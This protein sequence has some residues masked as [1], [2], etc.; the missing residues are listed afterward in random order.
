M[1]SFFAVLLLSFGLTAHAFAQT[2]ICTTGLCLQQVSCPGTQT[3]T[4][5]GFIY[6]PNGTDPLPNVTV[7][8]PNAAVDPFS[9]GVTCAVAGAPP[10][11][12]PIVGT[13]TGVDGKFILTNVPVGASIPIVAVSGRWRVQAQ[14]PMTTACADTAFSMNMP[15]N[16]TQG[17]IPKIAIATGS[18]DQVECVLLKMGIAQS[19]FTNPGG[20]GR[21]NLFHGD[22]SP[23]TG[24]V[25]IDTS[26]PTESILMGTND[27]TNAVLSQYDVLMLPCEGGAS[28]RAAQELANLVAFANAGGRVYASHFSYGWMYTNPPFNKVAS[29]T[30]NSQTLSD[31]IATVDTTFSEGQTLATWL[32]EVGATTIKGQMQVYTTRRDFNAVTPPTQSWLTL[33]NSPGNPTMQFVFDTPV[34]QATGQCGRVLFNEYHVENGSSNGSE[35]FPS[36]CAVNSPMTPQEKLLE[37]SLFELTDDG[38][39]PTLNPATQDFGSQPIGFPS[40]PQTFTWTNNSTFASIVNVAPASGDFS[41]TSSNCGSLAGGASCQISVV[42]T[43]TA[44]GA[45]TGTLTVSAGA[46]QLTSTLTGTGIPDFTI[47]PSSLAFGNLDVGAKAS[48]T[49]TVTS[50]A[51]FAIPFPGIVTTGDYSTTSTCGTSLAANSSCVITVTFQPTTTGSRPGTLAAASSNP[52]Y[53]GLAAT[54]TGNGIDFTIGLNPVS[55]STIAGYNSTSNATITPIAGFAASIALTCTTNAVAS[56]CLPG[57]TSFVPTTAVTTVVA[58]TTTSQYTI[59][60]YGGSTGWLS[61]L[62]FATGLLLW[63]KRRSAGTLLRCTLALCFFAAGSLLITGCTGKLPAQNPAYT[64][65]GD[66]TYTVTATDGFLV[67]SATYSL[68]LSAK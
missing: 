53:A 66:Y 3:T 58:I 64:A 16:K 23:G 50:D 14:V 28:V 57:N 10:S 12:S 55:G 25:V 9:A 47:S 45:R 7:Y 38:G 34:G 20:T 15:K 21:I 43:P 62:A 41:V 32:Q 29:W 61:L 37:F 60:G 40:A 31:G 44:L 35:N 1:R 39:I 65:P 42:F 6:A 52:A 24:G 8:I 59:V 49:I 51:P 27:S 67:H 63:F 48:Q 68:H 22:G 4:I 19:E 46:Q 13:T 54:M 17:D 5:T 2:P 11:G 18:V 56:T 33:N 30:G 26:T 36:E